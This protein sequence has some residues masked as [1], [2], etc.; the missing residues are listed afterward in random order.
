[1]GTL[2]GAIATSA[3]KLRIINS[4][5]LLARSATRIVVTCEVL[6]DRRGAQLVLVSLEPWA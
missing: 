3:T 2:S 6:L 1:M 5:K 4:L